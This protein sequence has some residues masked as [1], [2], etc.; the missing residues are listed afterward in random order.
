MKHHTIGLSGLIPLSAALLTL[1]A[2]STSEPPPPVGS[3]Y[4]KYNKGEG[5]G[6][7][8]Q[9][10]NVTATVTAIDQAERKVTFQGAHARKFTVQVVP[11]AVNFGQLRVGDRVNATVTEKVALSL[12]E[13]E[14]P[15]AEGAAEITQ[16]TGTVTAIDS[17]QRT[18]LL[19]FEDG[20]TGTIP[21]RDDADLSRHKVGDQIVFRVTEMTAIWV[22][23]TL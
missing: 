13:K 10:V 14:A 3:A 17:K 20:T 7:L 23:K 11:A 21:V 4:I 22:E 2:C 19:R 16:I 18:V 5:G 6:V 9:T 12:D 15:P 8:V 1:P